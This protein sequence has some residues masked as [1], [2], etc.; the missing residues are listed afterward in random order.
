MVE[1]PTRSRSSRRC[2]ASARTRRE[3]S[4]RLPSDDRSALSMS[5]SAACL[6]ASP[7]E[8]MRCQRTDIQA[9]ADGTAAST[10]PG[11]WTHALMDLGATICRARDPKCD[12]CPARPWCT[13]TAASPAPAR[14]R[15]KPPFPSTTRW[16]RGRI[17]DRLR[18]APGD[19]WVDFDAPIG[20]HDLTKVMAAATAMATEGLVEI[21][22]AHPPGGIGARL[23]TF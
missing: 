2:R 12:G 17:L 23:P 11:T 5:T 18:A 20:S 7:A 9:L 19:A 22:T 1:S 6:A 10:D 14:Q 8:G 3:R 21:A 13:Y 15:P 16:L 4:P